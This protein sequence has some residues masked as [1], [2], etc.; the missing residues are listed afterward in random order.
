MR[1]LVGFTKKITEP[2][3]YVIE[4]DGH[5]AVFNVGQF[6]KIEQS[7]NWLQIYQIGTQV[8]LDQ[9]FTTVVV[10]DPLPAGALGDGENW[11]D[12]PD[13]PNVHR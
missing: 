3:F 9:L 2:P 12:A 4:T 13:W 5:A 8:Y 10:N 1:H 7:G 6:V 11:S